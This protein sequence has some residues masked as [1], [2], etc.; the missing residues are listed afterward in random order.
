MAII[1]VSS[2]QVA[3]FVLLVEKGYFDIYGNAYPVTVWLSRFIRIT[4]EEFIMMI[5]MMLQTALAE[6]MLERK[7]IM[8]N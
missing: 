6:K 8:S 7:F 2:N 5:P 4:E 1:S 3:H